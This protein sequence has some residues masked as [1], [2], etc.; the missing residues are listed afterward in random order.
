MREGEGEE[1]KKG[2]NGEKKRKAGVEKRIEGKKEG[3]EA[4]VS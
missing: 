4:D 3:M 1:R 2:K